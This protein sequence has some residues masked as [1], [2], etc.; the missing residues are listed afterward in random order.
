MRL[1][2]PILIALGA[3]TAFAGKARSWFRRRSSKGPQ[4]IAWITPSG[5][6]SA[7]KAGNAFATLPLYSGASVKIA[8]GSSGSDGWRN[9]NNGGRTNGEWID[10]FFAECKAAGVPIAGH[11]YH[12]LLTPESAAIEGAR[13]A[14][15]A[16]FHKVK[17]YS[18]NC[19]R[20]WLKGRMDSKGKPHASTAHLRA[21]AMAFNEA[22]RSVAPNIRVH[23]TPMMNVAHVWG[24]VLTPEWLAKWDGLERMIFATSPNTRRKRWTAPRELAAT[25]RAINPRFSYVPLWAT[26]SIEAGTTYAGA[27]LQAA[28]LEATEPTEFI[29]PYYGNYAGTMWAT[30]NSYGPPWSALILKMQGKSHPELV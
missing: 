15:S 18:C 29:G 27:Q 1:W 26:G 28:E 16:L 24:P 14:E 7:Q 12:Y 13:A 8:D 22:F 19:E 17:A 23:I 3:L 21:T 11:G 9:R 4:A 25:A 10:L 5:I 6:R 30:G 2:I 20:Q